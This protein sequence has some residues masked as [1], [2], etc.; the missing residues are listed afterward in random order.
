LYEV[1]TETFANAS[2]A[3]GEP[4]PNGLQLVGDARDPQQAPQV[5]D[6]A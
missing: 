4:L 6:G 1:V 5:T 3:F 2:R